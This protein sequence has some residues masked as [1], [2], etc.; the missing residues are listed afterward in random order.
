MVF[1]K[2]DLLR[3]NWKMPLI[4]NIYCW[5]TREIAIMTCLNDADEIDLEF[6]TP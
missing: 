6:D 2:L 4:D 5:T 3:E 1:E